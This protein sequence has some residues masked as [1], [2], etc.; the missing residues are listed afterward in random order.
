MRNLTAAA[1]LAVALLIG[2]VGTSWSSD[3]LKGLEAYVSRDYATALQEFTPLAE[4]G[5]PGA[6]FFLGGMYSLGRGV[7]Q[8]YKAA[9]KWYRLAAEQGHA[10]AQ[11]NLGFMYDQGKGVPQN[12]KAALKWYRLA[13]Q[14]ENALAQFKLGTMYY[15]GEGVPQDY[16]RAHMW[17]NIAAAKGDDLGSTIRDGIAIDKYMTPTAIET[18]QRLARECMAKDYKGC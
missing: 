1:C 8:D 11:N 5:E 15:K 2:N 12:Y 13:A 10:G 14:Q 7:P 9:L 16:L 17:F 4:Q 6:Q 18:A 3:L